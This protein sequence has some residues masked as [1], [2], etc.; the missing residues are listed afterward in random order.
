MARI[1]VFGGGMLA[2][3]FFPK[4]SE[5]AKQML[6]RAINRLY[7]TGAEGAPLAF[8]DRLRFG[9]TSDAVQILSCLCDLLDLTGPK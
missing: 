4:N 8:D 3:D 6:V 1:A 2:H 9:A 5:Q 7:E